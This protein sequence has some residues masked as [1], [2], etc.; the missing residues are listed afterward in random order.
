MY[1]YNSKIQY[2]PGGVYPKSAVVSDLYSN[3]YKDT[4]IHPTIYVDADNTF[5]TSFPNIFEKYMVTIA[6]EKDVKAWNNNP[7]QF[8]QTQLH[9]A[10][11]CATTGCGV[12]GQHISASGLLGSLFRFH[13]YYQIR[14]ILNQL[15]VALPSDKTWNSN[16]NEFNHTEYN[17]LCN[18]FGVPPKSDWHSHSL[19]NGMGYIF[20]NAKKHRGDKYDPKKWSFSPIKN[21]VPLS[22]DEMLEMGGAN[23][24]R[25]F[26]ANVVRKRHLENIKQI[27]EEWQTFI[28]PK[29]E[30]FTRPGVERLN[31]SI[32]TYVWAILGAQAQTRTNII[33]V[34]TSF[35]AQHQFKLNVE[36]A[37]SGGLNIPGSIKRYQDTLQYASSKVDYVFGIGL[38]MAPSDMKLKVGRVVGYN[39]EIV[40]A[41]EGQKLGLNKS[42]NVVASSKSDALKVAPTQ[43]VVP[44]AKVV[45]TPKVVPTAKVVPTVKEGTLSG[46]ER[47]EALKI[48]L[49]VIGITLGSIFIY[50]DG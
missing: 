30:G 14:R 48:G 9:F 35:D 12:S 40:I 37:I 1:R 50:F 42:I 22:A 10:V 7:L 26:Q 20:V 49:C 45:P 29:S 15:K 31:D 27:S 18:E 32:R 2:K 25:M 13:V 6:S 17:K 46:G 47:H 44:T 4:L 19:N 34:G 39:N 3:F 23:I 28:L 16:N 38:Y 33:G 11:W 24:A 41:S 43:K 5:K 36:D 21:N 8:W